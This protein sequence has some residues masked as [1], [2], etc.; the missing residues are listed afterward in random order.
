MINPACNKYKFNLKNKR[1]KTVETIE[2]YA[3]SDHIQM[4]VKI[5]PKT[6][7]VNFKLVFVI[8]YI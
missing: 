7:V 6:N 4:L 2:A 5:P 3:T 8:I 1:L